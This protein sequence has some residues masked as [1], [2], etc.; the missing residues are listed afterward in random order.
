MEFIV[1]SEHGDF[2]AILMR[3]VLSFQKLVIFI[4]DLI[5]AKLVGCPG[6]ESVAGF[7]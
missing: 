3:G 4:D 1:F 6:L 2:V 7:F 5:L